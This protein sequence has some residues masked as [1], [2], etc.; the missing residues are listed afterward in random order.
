MKYTLLLQNTHHSYSIYTPTT[1]Q[2][3]YNQPPQVI[4]L[5][6]G[7]GKVGLSKTTG[8]GPSGGGGAGSIGGYQ[9][10]GAKGGGG[11]SNTAAN[12]H[13]TVA[14]NLSMYGAVGTHVSYEYIC[15]IL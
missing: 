14:A 1:I 8:D 12:Q 6:S 2:H 7:A 9:T 13:N 11:S 10:G 5:V 3:P 4:Q 15:C